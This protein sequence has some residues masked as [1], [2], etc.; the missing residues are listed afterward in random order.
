MTWL[1]YLALLI[2]PLVR[3]DKSI[4][5]FSIKTLIIMILGFL[6]LR[7]WKSFK[8]DVVYFFFGWVGISYLLTPW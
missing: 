7:K 8:F 2:V 3:Y 5:P 1:L 6:C 4:D